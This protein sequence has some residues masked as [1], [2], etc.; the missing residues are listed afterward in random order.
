MPVG[1]GASQGSVLEP[2][3]RNMLYDDV[4]GIELTIDVVVQIQHLL[5]TQR[6]LSELRI[7]T[8]LWET[9]PLV[10]DLLSEL[11]I[12][13]RLWETHPLVAE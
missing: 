10:A 4:L 5:M 12:A 8:R 11:R 1:T 9:H 2:A 6:L 13:T 3:R 7:A